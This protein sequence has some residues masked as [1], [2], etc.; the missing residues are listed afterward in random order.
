M[1]SWI[2]V[3]VKLA[4]NE[5]LKAIGVF[6]PANLSRDAVATA[7]TTGAKE[8]ICVCAWV[9]PEIS[10]SI[11]AIE[12]NQGTENLPASNAPEIYHGLGMHCGYCDTRWCCKASCCP[13]TIK[14]MCKWSWVPCGINL[15][16][17]LFTSSGISATNIRHSSKVITLSALSSRK[18]SAFS[19]AVLL[20][21]RICCRRVEM[22]ISSLQ[23]KQE[24]AIIFN[25][26]GSD[27][28]QDQVA[29]H[30]LQKRLKS[31]PRAD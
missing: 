13:S 2:P 1:I 17:S 3:G 5:T 30:I 19:L 15:T 21:R 28:G 31:R 10:E 12:V 24:V 9:W 4:K 20:L 18:S 7:S 23:C 26:S 16:V 29:L 25:A 22:S 11:K 8:P 27:H 14:H 6:V